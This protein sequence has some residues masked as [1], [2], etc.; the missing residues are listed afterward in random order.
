MIVQSGNCFFIEE[1]QYDTFS[2]GYNQGE[3]FSYS[4]H[5]VD[6]FSY[7]EFRPCQNLDVIS[8]ICYN[9]NNL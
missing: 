3:K 6:I 8:K 4:S 9:I 7:P 2:I 1:R 5:K